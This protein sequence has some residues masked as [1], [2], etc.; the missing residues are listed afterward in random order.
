MHLVS[1]LGSPRPQGNAATVLSIAEAAWSAT[2]SLERINLRDYRVNGCLG[3]GCC[4]QVP[5]EPGCVQPDDAP[6]LLQRL[7]AADAVI[8]ATPLYCWGFSAQLKAFI[9]RHFCLVT[10]AGGPAWKSLVEGKPMALL[11]TCAGPE[12][13]NAD[14]IQVVFDRIGQYLKGRIVG[15]YVVPFRTSPDR[16]GADARAVAERL[17]ADL[18]RLAAAGS[19]RP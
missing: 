15:K 6:A 2:C 7:L 3:C 10:E 11:V 12:A 14:L 17:A 18:A 4:Q 1:V 9:D 8:Y 13:G 16:L 5:G 19:M